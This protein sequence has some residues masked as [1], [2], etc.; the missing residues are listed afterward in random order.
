MHNP[1]NA[2]VKASR[3]EMALVGRVMAERLNGAHGPT[4]VMIPTRGWSIYGSQGGPLYDPVGNRK[5]VQALQQNLAPNISCTLCD[6][7]IN[8]QEFVEACVD[9]LLKEMNV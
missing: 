2:N 5:L 3:S 8:D 7:H 6:A 1:Y 4:A 9:V